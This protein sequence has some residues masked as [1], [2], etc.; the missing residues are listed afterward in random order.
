MKFVSLHIHGFGQLKNLQMDFSDGLNVIYGDNE[1]GKS[2]LHTFIECMLYGMYK[3][4]LKNKQLEAVYETYLPW[5]TEAYGGVLI[6]EKDQ[7]LYRIERDF[8]KSRER[9]LVFDETTGEDLSYLFHYN[10]VTRQIEPGVTLLGMSKVL[11]RNTVSIG[12]L[13]SKTGDGLVTEIHE[14]MHNLM[15]GDTSSGSGISAE[16]LL[17]KL[18]LEMDNIGNMRRKNSPF[19]K[20]AMNIEALKLQMNRSMEEEQSLQ[21]YYDEIQKI[22]GEILDKDTHIEAIRLRLKSV[23]D[24]LMFSK[25]ETYQEV[26]GRWNQAKQTIAELDKKSTMDEATYE[27]AR[28]LIGKLEADLVE[29]SALKH[30]RKDLQNSDRL[31]HKK[32]EKNLIE[33]QRALLKKPSG[34]S[35]NLLYYIGGSTLGIGALSSIWIHWLFL[36]M[37]V[38]GLGLIGWRAYQSMKSRES[39]AIYQQDMERLGLQI[40]G[41]EIEIREINQTKND[42]LAQID[43]EREALI[44]EAKTGHMALIRLMVGASIKVSESF[45]A[46]PSDISQDNLEPYAMTKE[47]QAISEAAANGRKLQE[48]SMESKYLKEQL[49]FMKKEATHEALMAPLTQ[50]TIMEENGQPICGD[51]TEDMD[52]YLKNCRSKLENLHHERD[53][54]G[55]KLLVLETTLKERMKDQPTVAETQEALSLEEA[56]MEELTFRTRVL[57]V[58]ASKVSQV[59]ED[60]ARNFAPKLNRLMSQALAIIS[61]GRYRDMKTTVDLKLSVLDQA[62]NRRVPVEALS[63]G[64]IDALYLTLRLG[65]TQVLTEEAKQPLVLD[66]PFIQYDH[67]RAEKALIYL[68]QWPNQ[69][70]FFTCHR[71]VATLLNEIGSPY[72]FM[73][74]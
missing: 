26:F 71:E 36:M 57:E 58:I 61:D 74:L 50:S 25:K 47:K 28:D 63:G 24:A 10:K 8:L 3:P 11:Y 40:K 4:Y 55:K 32:E 72:K 45:V 21:D 62:M 12:Q 20:T 65:L 16:K 35:G 56:S 73:K 22:K 34:Q 41:L 46:M 64:T 29:L 19:Y 39:L 15:L 60:V 14:L 44:E 38:V 52:Q 54:L 13:A 2:T 43:K 33:Q 31:N 5:H 68:S 67:K 9:V 59:S 42:L 7:I 18:D 17:A 70:L 48:L 51:A 66:D 27:I 69:Q 1:A 49:E 30:R 23:E 37:A 6:C 53:N